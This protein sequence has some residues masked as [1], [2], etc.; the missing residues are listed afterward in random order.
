MEANTPVLL[1]YLDSD[2]KLL[3]SASAPSFM[4]KTL[5]TQI[6]FGTEKLWQFASFFP[7]ARAAREAKWNEWVCGTIILYFSLSMGKYQ[8]ASSILLTN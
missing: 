4:A 8:G 1:T 7:N 6:P 5:N 2:C 3:R